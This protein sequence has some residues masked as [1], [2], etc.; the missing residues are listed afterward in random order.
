MT[1]TAVEWLF[2]Q[3]SNVAAGYVTE[4]NEQEIL[5]KAKQM[6]KE[7]ITNAYSNGRVD[8]QFKGTNASFYRKTSEQYYNETFKSE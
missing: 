8:E 6:E 7:Q 2:N 5:D 1:Q 4:L 3:M